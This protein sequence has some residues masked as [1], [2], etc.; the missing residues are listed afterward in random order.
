MRPSIRKN[1]NLK[2]R[3]TGVQGSTNA[4]AFV[5]EYFGEVVEIRIY[6]KQNS[7]NLNLLAGRIDEGWQTSPSGRHFSSRKTAPLRSFVDLGFPAACSAQAWVLV[8]KKEDTALAAKSGDAIKTI[9][10]DGTLTTI[11]FKWFGADMVT[12]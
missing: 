12:Q 4:E 8:C 9:K 2:G 5:Q 6:D 3:T 11:S 1:W 10:T 7:P